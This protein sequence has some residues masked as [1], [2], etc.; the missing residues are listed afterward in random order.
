[1]DPVRTRA[2]FVRC[3]QL[4]YS[5][6]LGAVHAYLG[7]RASLPFGADRA[8]IRKIL[9]DE[10]R[11]RRELLGMLNALGAGP[12]PRCERKMRRVGSAIAAFCAVGG[13][14]LPMVGAA[15]LEADNIVEYEIA[16]RLAWLAGAFEPIECLLRLAEVEW[17][18]ERDLRERATVHSMWRFVPHWPVPP[19]RESIRARFADFVAKPHA[20][21]RRVS[22]LVR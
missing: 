7:H 16:A 15:R 4:A 9:V 14:F 18:H 8:L 6:E 2:E 11:H 10:I 22:A 5:G 19:P 20:V 21:R 1:V 17:A 3:L 13:W 12:D